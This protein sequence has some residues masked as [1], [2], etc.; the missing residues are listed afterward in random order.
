MD[1]RSFLTTFALV[2]L[3]RWPIALG[4]VERS[5][6]EHLAEA[7]VVALCPAEGAVAVS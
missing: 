5:Q 7:A 2:E 3:S 1:G 6:V 4:A